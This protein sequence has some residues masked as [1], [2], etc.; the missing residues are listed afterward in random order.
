[1]YQLQTRQSLKQHYIFEENTLISK[2]NFTS[3]IPWMDVSSYSVFFLLKIYGNMRYRWLFM[4]HI[5]ITCMHN[6]WTR[7][8]YSVPSPI[9]LRRRVVGVKFNNVRSYHHHAQLIAP[10]FEGIAP[11]NWQ[12]PD[13]RA[14]QEKRRP[15]SRCSVTESLSSRRDDTSNFWTPFLYVV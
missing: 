6:M 15:E 3:R 7:V 8:C 4:S 2:C 5:F 11:A 9:V 1:M 13:T 10:L 14:L 12:Y